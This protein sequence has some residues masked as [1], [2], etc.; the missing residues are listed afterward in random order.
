MDAKAKDAVDEQKRLLALTVDGVFKGDIQTYLD[1]V[2]NNVTVELNQDEFDALA[3]LTFNIG[4]DNFKSSGL[5][6]KI[7]EDKHRTGEAKDRKMAIDVI[8]GKFKE[9]NKSKGVVNAD[10]V[11][12]RQDEANQFLKR[13]NQEYTDLMLKAKTPAA[14]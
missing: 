1:P 7:N 3:S 6:T 9:W 4:P 2:N 11:K 14:K 10:L 8:E 12:R 13:A 5:L